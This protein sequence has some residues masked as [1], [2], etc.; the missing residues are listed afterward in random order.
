[1][2]ADAPELPSPP[3]AARILAEIA[4][5][6][7]L[8]SADRFR[9]R[10]FAAAARALEGSDR[11]LAAL[12]RA[13]ELVSLPGI[14]PG[15]ASVLG[16]LILTGRS[17]LYDELVARTPVGLFD[18]MRI[19]G[20]GT[21]RIR[22]LHEELGID[23]LDALEAAGREGRIAQL[24]GFG[25]KT[26]E[27]LLAGVEFARSVQGRRLY[28]AALELAERLREVLARRPETVDVAIAGDLRRCL[29]VVDRVVLV[30]ASREPERT[31]E[32]FG[33]VNGVSQ[34]RE[35][36]GRVR[37]G[38]LSD[39]LAVRVRCV[40]PARFASA[41]L[42]E[43]GSAT[44]M[45]QLQARA[46]EVGL[47]LDRDGLR[48]EGRLQR[49]TSEASLYTALG[50]QYLAP[51]LREGWG[52]VELAAAQ[53]VPHLV[54]REDLQGT[55]HC[56]T[57]A[58]DGKSSLEEMASRAA[59]LGWQY[60][61]IAD[62][63]RTAAY[64]GGLSIEA[65]L[66]QAEEIDRLNR[67][68]A[69]GVRLFSGTEADILADGSLD[70]PDEALAQLDYVVGSVHSAFRLGRSAMTERLVRAIHNPQ[71]T[72]LGHAT[73]RLLL[74]R[75]GYEIDLDAVI[76][77]AVE[78]EVILEINAHPNRLDL[79]WR[80]VRRAAERGCLIAINPDAHSAAALE[81]VAYGVN[82]ARKAG[83]EPRQILNCW[84]LSEVEAYLGKR[85]QAG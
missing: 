15:I 4:L 83:L 74:R 79:D 67:S 40:A 12:A 22:T 52:E 38:V 36:E 29:E 27:K 68:G 5:L 42:W 43:T 14:G 62:H 50:L 84:S 59:E 82:V 75:E 18:L 13:G 61:G 19:P 25:K 11:D 56:H 51:E 53:Q 63:S 55:F 72:I 9:S 39:G 57:T 46:H 76:D 44:H 85:K 47:E 8:H 77:A 66:A 54:Q 69:A 32:A 65:L 21:A 81:H 45:E 28:P 24:P 64:A 70:F 34:V 48:R 37:E 33:Q 60:L 30:V 17:N 58:S 20:L 78:R 41:L 31:L 71:L 3:E 80:S 2:S 26:Q 23:S 7:E 6:L 16:E 35:G 1:M 49:S 10:A 73:G